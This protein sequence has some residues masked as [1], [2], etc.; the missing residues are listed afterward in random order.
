MRLVPVVLI[1]L[2]LCGAG[3]SKKSS[4]EFHRLAADQE[5]LVTREGDEAWASPEMDAIAAGLTTVPPDALEKERA[6]ALVA[7]IAAEKAR[8]LAEREANKPPPRPVVAPPEFARP[9]EEA[10]PPPT[11]PPEDQPVDAGRILLEPEQGMSEAE[12]TKLFGSCFSKGP[13]NKL[14]SGADATSVQV[15][16]STPACQ[17]RF[18]TGMANGQTLFLFGPK[19]LVEKATVVIQELDAG[20]QV[21]P[22]RQP[23]TPDPGPPVMTIPGMP[24]QPVVSPDAG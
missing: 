6:I 12:F 1:L 11:D 3:C 22:G 19:G 7:K 18:G 17:K 15:L 16:A 14:S 20:Q 9:T 10:S 13:V 21:I 8:V 2:A 5:I 23:P 4:K 24:A